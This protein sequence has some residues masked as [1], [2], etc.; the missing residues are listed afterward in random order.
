MNKLRPIL[1]ALVMALVSLSLFPLG[2]NKKVDTDPTVAAR[3]NSISARLDRIATIY[4]PAALKAIPFLAPIAKWSDD[5]V[6]AGEKIIA[7][8]RDSAA[9]GRRTLGAI[10]DSAITPSQKVIIGP[11]LVAI[12]DGLIELEKLGLFNSLEG[13]K[14]EAG[15]KTAALALK[16]VGGLLPREVSSNSGVIQ[17]ERFTRFT[18][19]LMLTESTQPIGY[20]PTSKRKGL[21]ARPS[22]TAF[23]SWSRRETAAGPASSRVA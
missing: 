11:L 18:A 13:S 7:N 15:I 23:T 8:I 22:I 4:T 6:K 14:I 19:S 3:F 2:C 1:A 20:I 12:G 10:V 21:S 5:Q 9:T 17:W 16:A